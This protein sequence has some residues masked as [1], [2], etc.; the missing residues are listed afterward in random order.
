M[1]DIATANRFLSLLDP[2]APAFTFQTIGEGRQ[3]HNPRLCRVL[4]GTFEDCLMDLT[5]LNGQGAAI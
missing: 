3:K 1:P 5:A 4:H 2:D